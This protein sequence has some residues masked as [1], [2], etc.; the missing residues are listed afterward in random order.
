MPSG[1]LEIGADAV[2]IDTVLEAFVHHPRSERPHR[3]A[4]TS[5]RT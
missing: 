3:A 2:G 1:V 4:E 5:R